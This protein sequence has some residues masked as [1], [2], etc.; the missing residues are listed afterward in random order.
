MSTSIP[1][2]GSGVDNPG[3]FAPSTKGADVANLDGLRDKQAAMRLPEIHPQASPNTQEAYKAFLER[4]PREPETKPL[5]SRK[6]KNSIG[7]DTQLFDAREPL[8]PVPEDA[9]LV[10]EKETT[11]TT[12]FVNPQ[13]P[14]REGVPVSSAQFYKIG[15]YAGV[16]QCDGHYWVVGDRNHTSSYDGRSTISRVCAKCGESV[17]YLERASSRSRAYAKKHKKRY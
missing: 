12:T 7:L 6:V 16:K 4:G 15:G 11:H 17:I 2:K 8:P 9:V 13:E 5:I 1:R 10:E 14:F 3:H